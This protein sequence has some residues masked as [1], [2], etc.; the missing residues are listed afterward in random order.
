L[1]I[2][3]VTIAE[4]NFDLSVRLKTIA[5]VIADGQQASGKAAKASKSEKK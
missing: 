4:A 2:A 1:N 5:V 3:G